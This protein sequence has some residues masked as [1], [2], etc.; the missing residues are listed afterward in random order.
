MGTTL[1]KSQNGNGAN[2][3]SLKDIYIL[4]INSGSSS[5]KCCLFLNEERQP[6]W[7]AHLEWKANFKESCLTVTENGNISKNKVEISSAHD[8]LEKLLETLPSHKISAV[9]HRVVHGGESFSNI[10]LISDEVKNKIQELAYLAPL[11]N[12]ANLEGINTTEKIFPDVSQFAV[13]DTA[14]H[15]TLPDYI[16]T[17]PIPYMWHKKAIKRYGFHGIS[18]SYCSK[19]VSKLLNNPERVIICHLGA[20]SSICAVKNGASINTSMGM[21]P[22]EGLMMASRSGSIDPGL[23]IHLLSYEKLSVPDLDYM[24]NYRSGLLGVSGLSQ[25]MRDIEGAAGKDHYQAKLALNMFVQRLKEYIGMMA[26]SLEGLDALIFTA[27]I[28]ENSS[29]V[30]KKTCDGLSFLNLQL[31]E[32]KNISPSRDEREISTSN[33]KVKIYV[34]PTQEEW[35]I[36]SQV[37]NQLPYLP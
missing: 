30:R 29:L 4:V 13:F 37:R 33:S 26:V 31:D 9:G 8:G 34:I 32:E 27:G 25:D 22:L 14:F 18:Y 16:S 11:H 2:D 28:G 36:G 10:T 7:R 5:H 3:H 35:E 20:G 6:L 23:I 24:L 15:T 21:T 1:Q 17:Y 12:P 19:R